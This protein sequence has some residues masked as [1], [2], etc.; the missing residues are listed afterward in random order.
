VATVLI[1]AALRPQLVLFVLVPLSWAASYRLLR[2]ERI[3]GPAVALAGINAIAANTHLFF[4]LAGVP[5]VLGWVYPPRERRRS[6]AL[7]GATVAGWM[8]SPYAL[9]WPEVFRLYFSRNVLT[10]YPSPISEFAPGFH[11]GLP[12]VAAGALPLGVLLLLPWLLRRAPLTWREQ[13]M[14]AG[15]WATG[16]AAYGYAVRLLLVWWVSLLPAIGWGLMGLARS[17]E[18]R[19]DEGRPPRWGFRA[20]LYTACVVVVAMQVIRGRGQWQFEALGDRRVATAAAE[21]LDPLTGWIQGHLIAGSRGRIYTS[22]NYGGYLT[23]RLHGAYST[24]DDSR[25][26]F[27]DS[28]AISDAYVNASQRPV[29]LGPWAAADLAVVP[30]SYRVSDSLAASPAWHRTA[31]VVARPPMIDRGAPPDTLVL[32]VRRDWWGRVGR[33]PLPDRAVELVPYRVQRAGTRSGFR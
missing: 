23:W 7:V 32:W 22:F 30:A 6:A 27:P 16:L 8:L 10:T 25:T 2:A 33:G 1:V 9:R 12:L 29:T 15:L 21:M 11:I 31:Y 28:I 18:G 14:A 5:A 20:A 24:S 19:A 13:V 4:P 17:R 3:R 26:I